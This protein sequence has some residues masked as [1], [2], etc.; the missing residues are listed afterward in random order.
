VTTSVGRLFDV[1][2]ALLGFTRPI[3][4]EAQ[5][6]IWLEQL[7]RRGTTNDTYSFPF[8]GPELD[9]RRLLQAVI[10]DRLSGRDPA[11]IARAFQRGVS[12]GLYDAVT[13]T[14]EEYKVDTVVVSGGVF[15]NDLL[16][17]D[18]KSLAANG[19]FRIWT[20]RAIPPNDGGLSLGQTALAAFGHFDRVA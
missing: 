15:Q 3:S 12:Q 4:F 8:F 7:A 13:A 18:L 19:T 16:L 1:A 6:A 17:E 20:N 11:E 2:A 10:H 9:F 5:A 14:C